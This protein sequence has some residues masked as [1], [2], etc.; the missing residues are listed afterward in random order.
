MITRPAHAR[1]RWILAGHI[2]LAVWAGSLALSATL[3]PPLPLPAPLAWLIG[4]T[5]ATA[6]LTAA[7]GLVLR[8]RTIERPALIVA[9]S[10]PLA[11]LVAILTLPSYQLHV[12][13]A[14]I[15]VALV[16]QLAAR[17]YEL[18]DADLESRAA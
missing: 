12:H 17:C 6:A 13:A 14:A 10:A 5:G 8:S 15:A 3:S 16:C 7:A 18:R 1:R 2:A 4:S 11:Y 9:L